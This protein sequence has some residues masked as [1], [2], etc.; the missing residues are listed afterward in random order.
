MYVHTDNPIHNTI[1]YSLHY[2]FFKICETQIK[3]ALLLFTHRQTRQSSPTV[4]VNLVMIAKATRPR[5]SNISSWPKSVC[6]WL[7]STKNSGPKSATLS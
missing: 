7:H 5:R 4:I 1:A 2:K 6:W 3:W